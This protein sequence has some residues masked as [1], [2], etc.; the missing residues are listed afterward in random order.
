LNCHIVG[1]GIML[2]LR[3]SQC[4][5]SGWHHAT[6]IPYTFFLDFHY[7]GKEINI[8]RGVMLLLRVI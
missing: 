4:I 7:C 8:A 5:S 6:P 2:L 1:R 3:R